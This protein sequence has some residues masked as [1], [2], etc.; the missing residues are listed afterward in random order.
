MG[1]KNN[2]SLFIETRFGN[3]AIPFLGLKELDQ[4]TV[5]FENINELINF[6]N[7][8]LNINLDD[9]YDEY[10]LYDY[11]INKKGDIGSAR[12]PIKYLSDNYDEEDL[13][14]VFSQ[15]LKEKKERIKRTGIRHLSYA[16]IIGFVRYNEAISDTD[17]D[18]AV[19]AYLK[20]GY[21]SKRKTYFILKY[22]NYK[23]KINKLPKEIKDN[24]KP[25]S[26]FD[27]EDPY[28]QSIIRYSSL[29]YE[30]HSNAMDIIASHDLDEIKRNIKN[31][32]YGVVDGVSD[33]NNITLDD[34]YTL[35]YLS[36]MSVEALSKLVDDYGKS[37]KR[38]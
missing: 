27:T 20:N 32:Y 24:S 12:L 19:G 2:V 3:I 9:V 14:H 5:G 6:L 17:I 13:K 18:L 7:K 25:L 36:G 4:F 30:E 26:S 33:G 1:N 35:E 29:G 38:K 21:L 15:Y 8:A 10:V 23:V 31:Q 16:P 22:D 37:K 11:K 28:L 34:I